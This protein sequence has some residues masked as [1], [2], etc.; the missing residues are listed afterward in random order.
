MRAVLSKAAQKLSPSSHSS[1]DCS[2]LAGSEEEFAEKK[3][4]ETENE[5]RK[6]EYAKYNLGSKGFGKGSMQMGG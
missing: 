3:K 6:E 2:S 4:R 1:K 5:K